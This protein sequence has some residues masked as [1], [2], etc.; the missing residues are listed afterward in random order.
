MKF[1]LG[2][3]L[4]FLVVAT[5][6]SVLAQG[7]YGAPGAANP[8]DAG[9]QNYN[10]SAFGEPAAGQ[11]SSTATIP[12]PK[13]DNGS[14]AA[15]INSMEKLE[16]TRK[17]KEG[18][19]ISFRIVEEGSG[20]AVK[21]LRI[22]SGGVVNVPHV[23]LTHAADKTCYQLAKLISLE[24]EKDFFNK[25]TVIIVLDTS[26]EEH[27]R[28]HQPWDPRFR[29]GMMGAGGD[30]VTIFGQVGR[31]GKMTLPS[32]GSLT[33]SSA[34]LQAGGFARFANTKKVRVLRKKGDSEKERFVIIVDVDSIMVSGYLNKDIPLRKDDVIIVPEKIVNF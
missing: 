1:F 31:Q 20:V 9:Y 23:G 7:A 32:D 25:A 8:L 19:Y 13:D 11:P 17:L 10:P 6:S 33:I 30:T 27:Q 3:I 29:N 4:G 26:W 2:L 22:T 5:S 21:R 14:I 18:D 15:V 16:K 34:I 24:L 12:V 28:R